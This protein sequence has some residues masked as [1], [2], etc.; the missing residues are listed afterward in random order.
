MKSA[1]PLSSLYSPYRGKQDDILLVFPLIALIIFFVFGDW[2]QEV[3][4]LLTIDRKVI[5]RREAARLQTIAIWLRLIAV[6]LR[7]IGEGLQTIDVK[8]INTEIKG[9]SAPLS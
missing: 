5:A 8:F 3:A 6:I 7:W 9:Q 2:L 1:V 4:L